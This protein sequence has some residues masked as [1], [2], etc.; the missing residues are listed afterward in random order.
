MNQTLLQKGEAES[1]TS[2]RQ[3]KEP[4]DMADRPK[5]VK[6]ALLL[7]LFLFLGA[8]LLIIL[9]I[10][11]I[12]ARSATT[13]KLQQQA[14]LAIAALTGSVVQPE[15][16]PATILLDLPGQTQAYTQATVYAQ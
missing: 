3:D 11:G 2:V 16:A 15:K 10:Y 5:K 1:Q 4:Q 6:R 12:M 7:K 9:A 14:N 8:V 13:E